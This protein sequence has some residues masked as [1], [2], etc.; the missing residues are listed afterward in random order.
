MSATNKVTWFNCMGHHCADGARKHR[1]MVHSF[2]QREARILTLAL[3]DGETGLLNRL[4]LEHRLIEM[5]ARAAGPVAVVAYAGGPEFS[6]QLNRVA[7]RWRVARLSEDSFGAAFPVAGPIEAR[8][9]IA[10]AA[11]GAQ[12]GV[13]VSPNHARDAHALIAAAELALGQARTSG[14]ALQTFERA[15]PVDH[16]DLMAAMRAALQSGAMSLFHQPKFDLATRVVTGTE[17]LARWWDAERGA[18]SPDLFV[19]IAEETGDIRALTEWALVQ[20]IEDARALSAAGRDLTVS[21]NISAK[22]LDDE[23]FAAFAIAQVRSADA[24]LC[25]EI[26]E[27]AVIDRPQIARGILAAFSDAGVKISIDDYGVRLSSLSYLTTLQADEVKID[28]SF[29]CEMHKPREAELIAAVIDLAH[30]LGLSVAAEGVE[31]QATLER[32]AALGCDVA[33][34]NLIGSPMRREEVLALLADA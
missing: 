25:F 2:Q 12:A 26:T 28:K 7:D 22:L 20:A 13:A 6:V 29:V 15:P 8:A 18:V 32:L 10:R 4:G 23:E 14:R 1:V 17:V 21:V 5:L 27:T 11:L 16:G 30:D 3:H 34:G 19:T 33:Q 24:K 31:T 9:E